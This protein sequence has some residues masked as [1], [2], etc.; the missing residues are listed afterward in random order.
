MRCRVRSI[1]A[2]LSLPNAPTRPATYWKTEAETV[3][4]RTIAERG[5]QLIATA[6]GKTLD[7]L[8]Q[9]PTLC[10]LIGGIQ[11]VTLSDEEA[12]RRGT[13]KTV[14]E[15]K[16][17]PT[18]SIL[19]EIQEK[20]RFAVHLDVAKTVDQ[21]LRGT[22][23][24]PQIRAWTDKG[25]V[26]VT[27]G[28]T[29]EVPVSPS[30]ASTPTKGRDPVLP[31]KVVRIYP[32]AVSRNRLDRAIRELRVPATVTDKLGSADLVL[33]LKS[34]EKR[35][36]KALREA[37]DGRGLQI[38]LVRSNTFT[39]IETVLKTAFALG[40]RLNTEEA[41]LREVEEAIAEV[42]S[43]GHPVE[44]ASQSASIRQFQHQL[45]VRYGLSSE[46]KGNDPTRRIV[47]YPPRIPLPAKAQA[48]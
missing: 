42:M 19:I 46:S 40:D 23:P 45:I 28:H 20:H 18:F 26:Q 41:A 22:A 9:N 7:N 10:D 8:I 6:H 38:H 44:L 35:Q 43:E 11:A 34:Q 47:I 30:A 5:V 15:R 12:N 24:H 32:Y 29:G 48:S 13:Q 36:P 1:P 25:E 3:A 14:L 27:N 16:A 39:Q 2:R 33:I 21:L 37:V 17:P 4:A 31:R